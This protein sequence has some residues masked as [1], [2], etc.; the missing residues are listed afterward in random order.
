ME[1]NNISALLRSPNTVFSFKD[2]SLI[3]N[4]TN[5]SLTKKY[6]YRYMKAGKLYSIRRGIYA[7]DKNYD[8]LELANKIFTPAYVS[9]ETVLAKEGVVFQKYDRIFVASYLTREI[10]CDGRAYVYRRL[11]DT[12]LLNASGIESK[13]NYH[14]ASKERAFLDTIYL[15]KNYHFDNL[16]SVNW[17]ECFR[18]LPIYENKVMSARL[19]SYFKSAKNA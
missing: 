16:S 18:I 10:L 7:K 6:A 12:V 8:R 17:E 9:F 14:I 13:E 5:S 4:E 11:K 15:N 19:R 3:W 2:L 1:N